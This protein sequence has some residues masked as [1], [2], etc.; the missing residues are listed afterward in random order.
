MHLVPESAIVQTVPTTVTFEE[1]KQSVTTTSIQLA[2]GRQDDKTIKRLV[3]PS[4]GCGDVYSEKS[5]AEEVFP[6]LSMERRH[7][8][9]QHVGAPS[10]CNNV[11]NFFCW[12]QCLD[13]PDAQSIEG[14]VNEGYSLYCLDPSVL[15]SSGNK[16]SEATAPCKDG[17]THNGKCQGSWQPTAPG[18]KTTAN[19]DYLKANQTVTL[20][21]YCYGGVSMY[22]DGFHW[23]HDSLCVV[24]L[25]P[26]WVLSSRGK[27][28]GAAIGT[29]VMGIILEGI[30]WQRR[31]LLKTMAAGK[32]RLGF[33]S[34][35][36]GAQ[37]TLG[38]FLMLVI[39]TY[40]GVLF[41]CSVAGLVI[42]NVL[43]N[44]KDGFL[45][46]RSEEKKEEKLNEGL[47]H[48]CVCADDKTTGA[49]ADPCNES[50][51]DDARDIADGA[52]PCCQHSA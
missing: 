45:G 49:A 32:A 10:D 25:F 11:T 28:A 38:Y 9:I 14:Y 12:Y 52:T 22:M 15:A 20:D 26:G 48:P 21:Q 30:I 31:H 36:Y 1:L 13:I 4:L 34:V 27:L 43:F 33:G 2:T 19:F 50:S 40:S 16:V 41:C 42:G 37:L 35:M 5:S 8:R 46:L 47:L 23:V 51:S 24:Y 29:L 6:I 18:V 39:M 17:Y 7:R 44:A 3:S